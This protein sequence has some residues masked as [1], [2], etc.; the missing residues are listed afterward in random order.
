MYKQ[1]IK[2]TRANQKFYLDGVERKKISLTRGNTYV[3]DLSDPSTNNYPFYI[4]TSSTGGTTVG[5]YLT[6]VTGNG[7]HFGTTNKEVTFIVG[8][9]APGC[10]YY[11]STTYENVGNK[12]EI[13][14]GGIRTQIMILKY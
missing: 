8:D 10:L 3:F 7:N 4:T 13:V 14:G 9:N 1:V 6:G 12:I 11:Q 2:V 5:Q